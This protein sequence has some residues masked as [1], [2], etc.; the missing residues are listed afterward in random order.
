VTKR[1]LFRLLILAVVLTV[2]GVV[3]GIVFL[4]GHAI[5]TCDAEGD[6]WHPTTLSSLDSLGGSGV[7]R[8]A[9]LDYLVAP[10]EGIDRFLVFQHAYRP[11]ESDVD[12]VFTPSS[13]SDAL[14]IY[15]Y[16]WHTREWHCKML[17]QI[18][19]ASAD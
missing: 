6:R 10:H 19:G 1:T 2:F 14:V 9:R 3:G 15:R 4:R 8:R 18:A 17:I 5:S 13:V 11:N 7:I 16:N 12:L